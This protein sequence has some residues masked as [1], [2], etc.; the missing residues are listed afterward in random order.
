M[1]GACSGWGHEP[2]SAAQGRPYPR[3]GVSGPEALAVLL[4]SRRATL[5]KR[6]VDVMFEDPFWADRFPPHGRQRSEEDLA[7]HVDYLVQALLA[8]DPRILERYARWLQEVLTARGMCT[9]HLADSFD[10]LARAIEGLAE[11]VADARAHLAAA[12]DA[13]LYPTGPARELQDAS[14]RIVAAVVARLKSEPQGQPAAS[15]SQEATAGCGGVSASTGS[16]SA[17]LGL[18]SA[19]AGDS[20][21]PARR[22]ATASS[23]QLGLRA[24]KPGA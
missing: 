15:A 9:I 11:D 4:E 13:L 18:N 21:P 14:P 2:R 19:M 7:F 22:L 5:A 3:R 23:D 12:R 20:R 24:E 6:V 10:E 17:P 16:D 1:P 8:S